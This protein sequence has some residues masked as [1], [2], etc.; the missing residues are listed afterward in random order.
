MKLLE[1]KPSHNLTVIKVERKQRKVI[2]L[3]F[4]TAVL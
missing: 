4:V 3:L 2:I 1:K